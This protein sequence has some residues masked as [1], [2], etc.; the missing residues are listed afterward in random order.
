MHDTDAQDGQRY[1]I[2]H[3]ELHPYFNNYSVYDDYDMALIT[4]Q[5]IILFSWKVHPI[6]LTTPADDYT[7]KWVH[8]SG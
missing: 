7:S 1:N 8:V 4:L 2:Q 5:Q 3:F 6:C